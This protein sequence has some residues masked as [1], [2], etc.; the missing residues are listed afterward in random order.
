VVDHPAVHA[1]ITSKRQ[2]TFPAAVLEAIGVGPGDRIE[3]VPSAEGYLLRAARVDHGK[4]AP[5]RH[6]I[7]PNTPPFDLAA[8]RRHPHEA[9]LRD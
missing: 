9:A 3:I 6:S 8:F 5:L 7:K 2:V 1:T 4:L